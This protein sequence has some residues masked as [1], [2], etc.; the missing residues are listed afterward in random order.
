MR[1]LV[2]LFRSPAFHLLLLTA[3]VGIVLLRTHIHP[4]DDHFHYQRFIETLAQGRLD[5]SIPG[6]QGASFLALPLYLAT[7]SPLANIHFQMLCALLLPAAGYAAALSLLRDRF[8]AVLFAYAIVLSPFLFFIAFRGFT[9]PSFTF[10]VLLTLWL[11]GRGSRFAFLPWS[12]SLITKPFSVALFPLF[13]LWKPGGEQSLWR[14]GWV[15]LLL[16]LPLPVLYVAIQYFQVGHIIVG[17]HS[18]IDQTNVFLWWRVPLNAAHGLQMLFSVHNYYFP[19]PAH[20]GH[21]NLMHSSPLLMVFGVLSFIIPGGTWKDVR[22]ARVLA[23][24]FV[25]AFGL[26]ASLDHMDHFYMETSVLL[27]ALAS[28]PFLARRLLLLPVVLALFHFPFFYLYLWGKGF[29][30]TD[31]SPFLIPITVDVL[32]LLSWAVLVMPRSRRAWGTALREVLWV[33]R[34]AA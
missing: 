2:L 29:Y 16:A 21:G 20:T 17:S 28:I 18:N 1:R 4:Q 13:L 8:Q 19:D 30:F 25:L 23:L 6:F 26:A 34:D 32:A 11:R 9:F 33:P 3:A 12:F 15:Q 14:R 7:R 24:C 27:L 5:L 31:F 10:L 22:L